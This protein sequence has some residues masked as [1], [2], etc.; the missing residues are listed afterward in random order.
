MRHHIQN[1]EATLRLYPKDT[2]AK[3]IAEAIVDGSRN[4]SDYGLD[5]EVRRKDA[6]AAK[7]KAIEALRA[8]TAIETTDHVSP[9]ILCIACHHNRCKLSSHPNKIPPPELNLYTNKWDMFGEN[10]DMKQ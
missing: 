6:I 9:D 3:V 1:L 5:D 10:V 8:G 7:I 4:K 2:P